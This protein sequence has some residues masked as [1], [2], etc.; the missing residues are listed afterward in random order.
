MDRE[1]VRGVADKAKGA[2]KEGAGKI[3]GDKEMENQGKLDKAKGSAHN[4]AGDVKDRARDA[5]DALKK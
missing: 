4:V 5:A 3:T 2:I 1:H